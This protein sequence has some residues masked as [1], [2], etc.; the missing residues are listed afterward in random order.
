MLIPKKNT[1]IYG[2]VHSKDYF[3][4][5]GFCKNIENN[6]IQKL[7]IYINSKLIDTIEAN[8][9]IEKVTELYDI[10][11]FSFNYNLKDKYINEECILSFKYHN[12]ELDIENSPLSLKNVTKGN[13]VKQHFFYTL[14]SFDKSQIE[15]SFKQNTIGFLVIKDN[16]EDTNFLKYIEKLLII[17]P[18]TTFKAFF[19]LDKERDNLKNLL[20]EFSNLK[21]NKIYTINNLVDEIGIYIYNRDSRIDS[22]RV[23]NSLLTNYYENILMIAYSNIL[24][25]E[26]MSDAVE[27]MK[28][29]KYIIDYQKYDFTQEEIIEYNYN[30]YALLFN[31]ALN[32]NSKTKIN[33]KIKEEKRFDLTHISIIKMGLENKNFVKF[34]HQ[35]KL[36]G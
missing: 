10:G 14:K 24:K 17:F 1:K 11:D 3:S 36:K 25:E 22:V 30:Y 29:S 15:P 19:F 20:G 18:N 28:N 12:T 5:I 27:R 9:K 33:Y 6:E 21:Y 34:F 23:L 7:D 8:K 13:F 26:T 4:F 32:L 35:I 31:K 2:I 16:M